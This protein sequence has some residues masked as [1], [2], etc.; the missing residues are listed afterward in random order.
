MDVMSRRIVLGTRG[1]RL[2]MTQSR[3]VK[4]L[5]ETACPELSVD[6]TVITT[7][8]DQDRDKPLS[9][10]GGRGAFVASIEKA[11]LDGKIDIAV[12]SLKDLPSTLPEGLMLGASPVREDPGDVIA[13]LN[14]HTLETLP[15]GSIIGTGSDRRRIQIRRIRPDLKFKLIRGNIETRLGKL[16]SGIYDAVVL[17]HAALER[18]ELTSAITQVLSIDDCLPAPCQGAIGIECRVDDSDITGYLHKI[19][20]PEV[21][22]CVDAERAF[23]ATLGLGCHSPVAAH[24]RISD[25]GIIFR[26]LVETEDGTILAQT[27]QAPQKNILGMATDL[28]RTF[29]DSINTV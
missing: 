29:R 28:A 4:E 8:G 9:E 25:G 5:L 27:V 2:A 11:L 13:A 16:G 21:R 3:Q 12:H 17:A 14:S 18:L 15:E 7:E 10:F 1:S 23:I 24:A 20:N 26:A 22:I 6:L 19:D